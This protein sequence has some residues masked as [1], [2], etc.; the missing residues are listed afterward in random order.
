VTDQGPS[1]ASVRVPGFLPSVH[2]LHFDNAFPDGP[3]L[4]VDLGVTKLPIGNAANGLCGGMV[5]TVLDYWNQGALPP[6]DTTPPASGTPLFDY[7]VRRLISSWDLPTGPATYL[8][9]MSPWLSDGD[10]HLGPVSV[11]GRSWRMA[12][13]E[14]PAI[15]ATIDGGKPCP[16]GLVKL[17]SANPLDLG[18]NHQ[19]LAY[20]YDQA[21]TAI[22][23]W[24]YD[25][26]QSNTDNVALSLD[27]ARPSAPIAVTMAPNASDPPDVLCFFK[28][29]YGPKVPPAAG[30]QVPVPTP[31]S[32]PTPPA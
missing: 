25:P 24:L 17:K 15:K 5:F 22:T 3:A 4:T 28:V 14:W 30:S 9:L 23:M 16:L 6:P 32:P 19:V 12:V 31:P 20:G 11:H 21:G 10:D 1:G 29:G 13:R 18:H 7:L 26:N 8:K 27:I 2:G